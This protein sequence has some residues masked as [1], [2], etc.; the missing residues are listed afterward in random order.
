MGA[1]V[2]NLRPLAC[3][4]GARGEDVS[5]SVAQAG[6]GTAS[7]SCWA[8]LH[9][10]VTGVSTIATSTGDEAWVV[11]GSVGVLIAL[12]LGERRFVSRPSCAG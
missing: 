1:R 10:V 4:V 3:E 7:A 8:W 11:V 9:S 12:Q 5:G 6:S 2:S